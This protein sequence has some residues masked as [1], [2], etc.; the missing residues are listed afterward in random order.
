MIIFTD[1][2]QYIPYINQRIGNPYAVMNLSSLYSG[3]DNVTDLITKLETFNNTNMPMPEFVQ[4]VEFDR[5]FA[6]SLMNDPVLFSNLMKIMLCCRE[7]YTVIILVQRDWYRDAVM[8]SLSKFIQ[9]R[10]GY[11]TWVVQDPDDI[12]CIHECWFTPMGLLALDEDILRYGMMYSNGM[13]E[14]SPA[15]NICNVE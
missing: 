11:N 7:G 5:Q 4:S 14:L 9:Q 10:Y 8:E 6:S 2:P 15:I 3:Y 1:N 13:A 12:E